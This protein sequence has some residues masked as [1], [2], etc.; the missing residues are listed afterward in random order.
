MQTLETDRL[1]LRNF[2]PSDWRDLRQ[3][4]L[5]YVASPYAIYD[6]QWPTSEEELQG[7]AQWFAGGDSYLAVCLRPAG[8]FIGFVCL[9]PREGETEITYD[10]GYIF[11]SGYHGQGYAAEAGRAALR[12]AFR[13]LGAAQVVAGT[14]SA[15][16]PS[17]RLLARLGLEPIPGAE[18]MYALH[19]ADWEATS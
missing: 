3:M 14:A 17:C 1:T 9:N 4:I 10:L 5:Q 15:N 6:H 13:D 19:R 2:R 12:R 7:V 11:N 16:E 18:G 8:T